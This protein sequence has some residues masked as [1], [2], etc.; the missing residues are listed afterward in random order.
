MAGKLITLEQLQAVVTEIKN[1]LDQKA[2]KYEVI[3]YDDPSNHEQIEEEGPTSPNTSGSPVFTIDRTNNALL[4]T[5]SGRGYVSASIPVAGTKYVAYT[6]D[7]SQEISCGTLTTDKLCDYGS[8]GTSTVYALPNS[9]ATVQS[10]ARNSNGGGVILTTRFRSFDKAVFT[11]QRTPQTLNVNVISGV[12]YRF[13]WHS[14]LNLSLISNRGTFVDE[15]WLDISIAEN[16]TPS[17]TLAYSN[18]YSLNWVSGE[19]DWSTLDGQRVQIH[20]VN[21]IASYVVVDAVNP[22]G[23]EMGNNPSPGD[24]ESPGRPPIDELVSGGTSDNTNNTDVN[25]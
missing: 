13:L 6:N 2:Y 23:V 12:Y 4:A 5:Y 24:T 10:A 15:Y 16:T 8:N 17:I 7:S 1:I 22:F 20:I 14:S 3:T 19:P 21:G 9:S 18:D 11:A 25:P